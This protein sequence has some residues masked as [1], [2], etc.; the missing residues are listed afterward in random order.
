M[1]GW[2]ATE[3]E[4]F[5]MPRAEGTRGRGVSCDPR[6][7]M[8]KVSLFATGTWKNAASTKHWSVWGDLGR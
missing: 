7:I 2:L 6:L 5:A 4:V 3:E 8:G 1:D